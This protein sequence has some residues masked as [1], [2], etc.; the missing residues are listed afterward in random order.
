MPSNIHEQHGRYVK[1]VKLADIL[2][3]LHIAATAAEGL[4]KQSWEVFA[5]IAQVPTPGVEAQRVTIE[6]L[7]ARESMREWVAQNV[8]AGL[9]T[10]P[11]AA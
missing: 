6:L 11:R 1:A 5:R 2:D 9:V 4:S 10:Q 7:K 8:I 3:A